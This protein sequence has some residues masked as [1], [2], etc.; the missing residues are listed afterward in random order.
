MYDM[1]IDKIRNRLCDFTTLGI[2]LQRVPEKVGCRIRQGIGTIEI[3]VEILERR[4]YFKLFRILW[5][6][7][8]TVVKGSIYIL[9]L[10]F[11]QS[12]HGNVRTYIRH[13]RLKFFLTWRLRLDLIEKF[14]PE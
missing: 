9:T 5:L 2:D 10:I 12:A 4:P 8:Y 1:A 13:E 14:T 6:D 11:C 3:A 7:G